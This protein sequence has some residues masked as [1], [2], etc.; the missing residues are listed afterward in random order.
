MCEESL[1]IA[2]SDIFTNEGDEDRESETVFDWSGTICESL[3]V[4]HCP[5]VVLH[6]ADI[7]IESL[8][9]SLP[10]MTPGDQLLSDLEISA[11][12]VPFYDLIQFSND[13]RIVRRVIDEVFCKILKT[14]FEDKYEI[15]EKFESE[16]EEHNF[17]LSATKK[18]FPYFDGIEESLLK[19][20]TNPNTLEQNR[21][22]VFA[23]YEKFQNIRVPPKRPTYE[24]NKVSYKPLTSEEVAAQRKRKPKKKR[25]KPATMGPPKK[26]IRL[27]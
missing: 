25:K 6:L 27:H 18:F 20:A 2:L 26:K 15:N 3:R 10:K 24:D 14:E 7:F 13:I 4:D 8:E 21:S 19:I 12:L 5:A 1:K 22:A 23:L 11:L 9:K 17:N 16:L